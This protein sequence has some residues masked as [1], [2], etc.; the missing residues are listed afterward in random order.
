MPPES[1]AAD[2][3]SS[4]MDT[5]SEN[6]AEE[7]EKFGEA[8]DA[9]PVSVHW[10]RCGILG[11]GPCVFTVSVLLSVPGCVVQPAHFPI[12]AIEF[13][14]DTSFVLSGAGLQD[15]PAGNA[16]I[17]RSI[18]E[19]LQVD[20]AAAPGD[21]DHDD[22]PQPSAQSD[23]SL[24]ASSLPQSSP[25]SL[26]P[27][28]LPPHTPSSLQT[29]PCPSSP[30]PPP[31]ASPP[32]TPPPP[33]PPPVIIHREALPINEFSD[34]DT[35]LYRAFPDAF[36]LGAGLCRSGPVPQAL[37]THLLTAFADGDG[38]NGDNDDGC[39]GGGGGGGGGGDFALGDSDDENQ[40][41]NGAGRS[42]NDLLLLLDASAV[43][44]HNG[45]FV[46]TPSQA[47][48]RRYFP[49]KLTPSQLA[50][51]DAI[52]ALI[53]VVRT[54]SVGEPSE[55]RGGG[56]GGGSSTGSDAMDVEGAVAPDVRIDDPAVV[57][58]GQQGMKQPLPDLERALDYDNYDSDGDGDVGD[59]GDDNGRRGAARDHVLDAEA[60]A[61]WQVRIAE[62]AARVGPV[63]VNMPTDAD[64]RPI[65][66][67]EQFRAFSVI[68]AAYNAEVLADG[69]GGGAS[70]PDRPVTPIF[71]I[72]GPGGTGKSKLTT[73]MVKRLSAA[74]TVVTAS[75]GVAAAVLNSADPTV[76]ARTVYSAV[77]VKLRGGV[78]QTSRSLSADEIARLR[79]NLHGGRR[80]AVG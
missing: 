43:A 6:G 20:D 71:L 19:A 41:P 63:A 61:R 27:S 56:G 64:G 49:G 78:A 23:P 69:G 45:G 18:T 29:P 10:G 15:A 75:T 55:S 35:L 21:R 1:G 34:N 13:S 52:V 76:R 33:P 67:P 80:D 66:G 8:E 59:D 5:S 22:R 40:A 3:S 54:R 62:E 44:S 53:A 7:E 28:S 42:I 68:L 58:A 16:A 47:E 48:V 17:L 51:I 50:A 57:Q 65:L 38:P 11:V 79:L 30:P 37:V 36:P 25:S 73:E 77:K 31:T 60:Q 39:G 9:H 2:T 70:S 32:S 24:A 26:P 12:V 74:V 14:M 4:V 46:L 72:H